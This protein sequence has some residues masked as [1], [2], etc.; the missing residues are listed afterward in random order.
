MLIRPRRP[1]DGPRLE[2]IA[3][4]THRLDAYPKYLPGDVLSFLV[5]PDALAGWVAEADGEVAGHVAL[6]A[7]T[8]AE[9]MEAA[10]DA[11]GLDRSR[12]A[13]VA[14]LL[15]SPTTRRVGAGRALL[16]TATAEARRLGR[17]AVLDVVEE[18]RAAIALYERCGW[19]RAGRVT[20]HLPDGRPLHEFVYLA[21]T[22]G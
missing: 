10:Q 8:A 9:V 19:I 4:E 21:P 14:R 7:D 5:R 17:R 1:S 15:V 22:S 6:H 3:L 16:G 12:L 20:W 18:H 2:A 11:T 13:V